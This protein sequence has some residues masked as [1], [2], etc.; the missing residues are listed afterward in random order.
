MIS[1]LKKCLGA[2]PELPVGFQEGLFRVGEGQGKETY[3][4]VRSEEELCLFSGRGGLSQPERLLSEGASKVLF[5]A[6]E[7]VEGKSYVLIKERTGLGSPHPNGFGLK[8][9]QRYYELLKDVLPTKLK[10][11][12]FYVY[13]YHS[14]KKNNLERTR[15]YMLR[16]DMDLVTAASYF[17]H[18][19]G[20][21]HSLILQIL[22]QLAFLH[23]K[24]RVHLDIKLDNILVYDHTA[25]RPLALLA[26]F[27]AARSIKRPLGR[28][29]G[30]SLYM[31]PE[32]LSEL[33]CARPRPLSGEAMKACDVYSMGCTLYSFLVNDHFERQWEV[34]RL[35]D[36][37]QKTQ[38]PLDPL[39]IYDALKAPLP[40][41]SELGLNDPLQ[42]QLFQL[43]RLALEL[44]PKKRL[45]AGQLLEQALRIKPPA[46]SFWC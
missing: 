9:E 20:Q 4:G 2:K 17:A 43:A 38:M 24:E 14:R 25:R 19:R 35:F 21:Q 46:T 34:G 40:S 44:D 11:G 22:T 39:E 16:A 29:L 18:K 30:S 3:V 37:A 6:K 23:E 32:L 13:T 41:E 7:H 45:T 15:A 12:L 27:G 26:D 36:K 10:K 28:P 1:S 33:L 31:A 8:K 5:P 42:V